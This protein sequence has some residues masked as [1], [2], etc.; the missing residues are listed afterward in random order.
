MFA[1]QSQNSSA[2]LAMWVDEF[3]QNDIESKNQTNFD[4]NQLDE[5]LYTSH[6]AFAFYN[7]AFYFRMFKIT[8]D[9]LIDTGVMKYLAENYYTKKLKFEKF[10]SGPEVLAVGDL[11]FGF[12]IWLGCCGF[13][14]VI[15]AIEIIIKKCFAKIGRRNSKFSKICPLKELQ[16]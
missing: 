3:F 10:E 6:E 8:V 15:F 16:K 2:K 4:W 5:Y 13:S 11:A 14:V 9:R 1:T 12:N 7:V